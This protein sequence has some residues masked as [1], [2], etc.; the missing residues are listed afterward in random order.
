ML[1]PL[2]AVAK[3]AMVAYAGTQSLQWV[4]DDSN[5]ADDFD[6]NYLRN[7]ITPLL[8]ARWPAADKTITRAGWHCAQ[9]AQCLDEMAVTNF[10]SIYCPEDQSM[11]ISGLLGFDRYQQ[12]LI[13]RHWFKVLALRMPAT[14]IIGQIL[15]VIIP[16]RVDADPQLNYQHGTVRR[17]RSK[18]YWQE[19]RSAIDLSEYFH[20]SPDQTELCLPN[21]GK[22]SYGITRQAGI[23][24]ATWHSAEIKICYRQ[25]GER[26]DLPGRRGSHA[27]KKLFQEVGIPPW[28][29]AQI[30][31]VYLDGNLAAIGDKWVSSDYFQ[32]TAGDNIQLKW[33]LSA[34]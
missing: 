7:Q 2:L 17:Y 12:Q 25:G 16:A 4:E 27:L 20:W 13:I 23:N 26:I 6:R 22:L 8:K 1:R 18:L 34:I 31:L 29:R 14:K 15:E 30:P 10:L 11:A 33:C 19:H 32:Q 28:Q 24:A 3:Q 5:Q 9:A 21:N